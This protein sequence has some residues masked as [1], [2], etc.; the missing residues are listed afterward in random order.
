MH[1]RGKEHVYDMEN[2]SVRSHLLK[3]A[4]DMHEGESLK[5]ID[6]RMRV[7][8]FH[9][10][11]FERQVS[12]AVSIQSIRVGNNLLNSKAE[13]NRCAVPRLA[14][15]MGTRNVVEDRMKEDEEDEQE[16]NIFEKIKKMRKLAG[17]RSNEWGRGDPN[18]NP[19]PKRRKV[20]DA[21]NYVEEITAKIDTITLLMETK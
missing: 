11:S 13:F 18:A 19:A 16:K 3:H 20:D 6:F 21:N 2:L 1:K 14:L 10:S 5:V 12:E 15:K 8:K 9:R 7:I 17:K 4:V